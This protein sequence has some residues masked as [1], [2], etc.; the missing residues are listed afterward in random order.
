[1]YYFHD[2][3]NLIPAGVSCTGIVVGRV[4]NLPEI[5]GLSASYRYPDVF[6]SIED[7]RNPSVVFVIQKNGTLLGKDNMISNTFV[8]MAILK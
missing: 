5:S 6:Y 2:D 7:S 4:Q 3:S 8:N 1:M